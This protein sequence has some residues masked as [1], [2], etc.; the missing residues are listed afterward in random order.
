LYLVGSRVISIRL[1]TGSKNYCIVSIFLSWVPQASFKI[2][3]VNSEV[4]KLFSKEII[5]TIHYRINNWILTLTRCWNRLIP[6]FKWIGSSLRFICG[7]IVETLSRLS[8]GKKLQRPRCYLT[9]LH[10]GLLLILR[11]NLI[12]WSLISLWILTLKLEPTK[13]VVGKS[14]DN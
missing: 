12:Y 7:L 9:L 13:T 11:C 8:G 6:V 10:T 14:D 4:S 3:I 1:L 5:E 2:V